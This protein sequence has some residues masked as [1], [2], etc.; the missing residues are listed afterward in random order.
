MQREKVRQKLPSEGF[1]PILGGLPIATLDM[2]QSTD[3]LISKALSARGQMD[4]PFF[5]TSANGQVIA[6]ASK[7]EQFKSILLAADQIHAD[8]M[9]M[10]LLSRFLTRYPLR[11]RVATTDLVH[12]VA[13][14]AER[15]GLTFYF[16]GGTLEVNQ[17]AVKNMSERFPKLVF[18][19]ASHGFFSP[20]QE[21]QVVEEIA[22]LRPD[23]LWVGLGVP[24][25][26]QFVLRNLEKLRGVGVI[27]TSGGL[28]DFVAGR[29]SRA[30]RWMQSIGLEWAYRTM[31]EP[32][33]LTSR[34]LSTNPIALQQLLLKSR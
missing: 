22:R 18:A 9:P 24:F 13:A 12:S 2:R 26:Q 8:G 7:D 10:V 20:E 3:L 27:K 5:S 25:E 19:G 29:N 34:Y 1:E 31:L 15:A 16:L 33:R 17:K 14:E 6:L 30:P 21:P 4:R 11:E 28:F 23:I 32:R